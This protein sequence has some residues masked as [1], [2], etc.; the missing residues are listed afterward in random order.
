MNPRSITGFLN[1]FTWPSLRDVS[2]HSF[3]NICFECVHRHPASYLVNCSWNGSW[4]LL[5]WVPRSKPIYLNVYPHTGDNKDRLLLQPLQCLLFIIYRAE[6][7]G[8][9][10]AGHHGSIVMQQSLVFHYRRRRSAFCPTDMIE[11]I[12]EHHHWCRMKLIV[13][14]TKLHDQ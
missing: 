5:K 7:L 3:N 8:P 13:A 11:T 4:Q 12:V 10:T 1:S 9:S 14:S 6:G 2:S